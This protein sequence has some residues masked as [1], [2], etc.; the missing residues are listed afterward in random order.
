MADTTFNIRHAWV[1]R[2]VTACFDRYRSERGRSS[3]GFS[4]YDQDALNPQADFEVDWVPVPAPSSSAGCIRTC[5]KV[6]RR[7]AARLG[8]ASAETVAITVSGSN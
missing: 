2:G 8:T 4:I 3:L 1:D 7:C 5:R 6:S